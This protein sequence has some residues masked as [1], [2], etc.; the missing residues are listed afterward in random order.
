MEYR[1]VVVSNKERTWK[2][3]LPNPKFPNIYK[4]PHCQ[5]ADIQT[6]G[7]II[8]YLGETCG[9]CSAAVISTVEVE[10]GIRHTEGNEGPIGIMRG[11]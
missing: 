5:S 3:A 8:G 4:C 2:A 7:N 6:S 9:Y 10:S 11:E 1:N